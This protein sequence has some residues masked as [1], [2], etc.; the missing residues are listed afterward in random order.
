MADLSPGKSHYLT[1]S[2]SS[3]GGGGDF[4]GRPF[5]PIEKFDFGQPGRRSRTPSPYTTT[6]CLKIFSV[7]AQILISLL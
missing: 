4:G 5:G 1:R 3:I 2:P 7:L 6:V